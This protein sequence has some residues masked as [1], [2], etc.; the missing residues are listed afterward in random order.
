MYG[1]WPVDADC[2][3]TIWLAPPTLVL[4]GI[5]IGSRSRIG[6]RMGEKFSVGAAFRAGKMASIVARKES[7]GAIAGES[8]LELDEKRQK[9]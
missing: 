3:P 9:K 4:G 5:G 2:P 6:I 7:E 8:C 1:N